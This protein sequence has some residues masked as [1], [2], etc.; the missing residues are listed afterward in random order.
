[1]L[2]SKP[3]KL[4]GRFSS[5]N[6]TRVVVRLT[7]GPGSTD[8]IFPRCYD[9]V[10]IERPLDSEH[11]LLKGR[12]LQIHVQAMIVY[13]CAT[14]SDATCRVGARKSAIARIGA[15]TLFSA[16]AIEQNEVEAARETSSR[17][18]HDDVVKPMLC[19]QAAS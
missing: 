2:L 15:T 12:H 10:R 19:E 4:A 3:H 11:S 9:P 14:D 16:A 6:A 5:A 7:Y 13:G 18:V 1:L 17:D 8:T